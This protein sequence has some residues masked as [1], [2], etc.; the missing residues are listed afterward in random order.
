MEGP[1]TG[2]ARQPSQADQPMRTPTRESS[3]RRTSEAPF[4]SQRRSES[5][6][7]QEEMRITPSRLSSR[8]RSESLRPRDEMRITP[9]QNPSKPKSSSLP[10]EFRHGL[11]SPKELTEGNDKLP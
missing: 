2:T 10:I 3:E 9:V 8:H 1:S 11:P 5:R 6:R 7:P 4:T